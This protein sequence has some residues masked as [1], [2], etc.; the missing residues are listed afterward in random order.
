M[1][2]SSSPEGTVETSSDTAQRPSSLSIGDELYSGLGG[3][4]EIGEWMWKHELRIS[5][6]RRGLP[7]EITL[8]GMK[9]LVLIAY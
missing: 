3:P 4:S 7:L 1:E 8:R 5:T 2:L 6:W 9:R